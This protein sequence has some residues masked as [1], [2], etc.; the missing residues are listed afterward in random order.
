MK[1]RVGLK[2]IFQGSFEIIFYETAFRPDSFPK[3][4]EHELNPLLSIENLLRD[5]IS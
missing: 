1:K 3:G 4:K 5:E 2:Q